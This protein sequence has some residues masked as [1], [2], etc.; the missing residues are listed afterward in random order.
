MSFV[1]LFLFLMV[2]VVV[3]V[4]VVV[5]EFGVVGSVLAHVPLCACVFVAVAVTTLSKHPV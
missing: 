4:L 3:L 2:V 5:A 1:T